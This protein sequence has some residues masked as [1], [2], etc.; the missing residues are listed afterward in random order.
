MSKSTNNS[1]QLL[2]LSQEEMDELD[3]FLMSDDTSDETMALETLDGYLTAIVS[4]PVMLKL[5][6]WLPGVWGPTENDKPVFR[7]MAQAKRIVDLILRHMNGIIGSLQDDP[8]TFEPV[9]G[10]RIYKKR[11]YVDGEMWAYGYM[12]G[13]ELCRKQWQSFFDDPNGLIVLRPIHLLGSDDVTPEEE[14]LTETPEQREEL[15]KQIPASVGW[16]Y[17]YWLP[18]R[19]AVFERTVATTI[20][21]DQPKIGR[22]DPCPCGSGLKFKKCC[23]I[24][25][26]LH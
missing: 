17:S 19:Q 8:N 25:A 21:R 11:E 1:K 5:N 13:I 2:P 12:C 6:D 20:Q 23:G 15:S 9:F 10:I 7:T 3:D 4:G 24:S 18:Y 16:I 22:N 26:S 14:S